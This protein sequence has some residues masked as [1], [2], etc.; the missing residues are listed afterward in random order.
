MESTTEG[1]ATKKH[2]ELKNGKPYR[3]K[4]ENIPFQIVVLAV[5]IFMSSSMHFLGVPYINQTQ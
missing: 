1:R 5:T 4:N 3:Q 2:F